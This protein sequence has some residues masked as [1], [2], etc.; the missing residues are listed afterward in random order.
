MGEWGPSYMHIERPPDVLLRCPSCGLQQPLTEHRQPRQRNRTYRRIDPSS[1]EASVRNA[2]AVE[3]AADDFGNC[4]FCG[5]PMLRM[6][7]LDV[8]SLAANIML[9]SAPQ[10]VLDE[11]EADAAAMQAQPADEDALDELPTVRIEPHVLL[12]VALRPRGGAAGAQHAHVDA[13][14]A[15]AAGA[16]ARCAAK[17]WATTTTAAATAALAAGV[18]AAGKSEEARRA[19]AA[20]AAERRRAEQ[21]VAAGG[22]GGAG[23]QLHA[24]ETVAV[25]GQGAVGEGSA[26]GGGAGDCGG[27]VAS[28]GAGVGDEA[29]DGKAAEDDAAITA[30]AGAD[31]DA[32]A[33]AHAGAGAQAGADDAGA[34]LLELRGT[35]STFG[36]LFAELPAP[37][38]AEL[39][40]A[41]PLD[42]AS[43]F[44]NSAEVRGKV[45]LMQRGGCS[46]VDK[47]RRAQSAGAAAAVVIQTGD[48]WPFSMSDT[49]MQGTDVTLP[50]M[51][52]SSRD[53]KK[54]QQL[55]AQVSAS[56]PAAGVG[57]ETCPA[58]AAP[59]SASAAAAATSTP[60][61]NGAQS[62]A[63]ARAA[64]R[65]WVHIS[66]RDHRTACA[67]CLN[68]MIAST[69][70]V[71]LP[72]KHVFHTECVRE[73]LR[74]Q[75]TCPSCR[76]KLPTKA[77]REAHERARHGD[78][79][80]A[81]PPS[82]LDYAI[83]SGGGPMPS[84]SMYT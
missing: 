16:D 76:A 32:D 27:P 45:V 30:G 19:L 49:Q 74:K 7:G 73:W 21:A 51:M 8:N 17:T 3:I 66:A 46:F 64:P 62:S 50:S 71:A 58:S 33:G 48:V 80:A 57:G 56:V 22:E 24:H 75:H 36:T 79:D 59:S 34:A 54:L 53:G 47:V 38:E 6:N 10:A 40:V 9:S 5:T 4:S 28:A 14:G 82:W 35:G 13:A 78:T 84:S 26:G 29:V 52:L 15:A 83:P 67:V 63:C 18:A 81:R 69:L 44:S 20:E 72:C 55:M 31:A 43:D 23:V 37:I 42:G 1:N 39:V 12:R 77:E 25:A 65:V 2:G 41:D 60:C 61:G 68:E 11:L 70:A